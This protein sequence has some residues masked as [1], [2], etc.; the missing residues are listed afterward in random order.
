LAAVGRACRDIDQAADLR[1]IAGLGDDG[2]APG[3]PS[4][5]HGTVLHLDHPMSGLHVVCE[6]A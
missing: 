4:E 6:R 2:A 3:M 1:L 5:Q